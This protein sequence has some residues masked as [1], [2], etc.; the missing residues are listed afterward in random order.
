VLIDLHC[1][2]TASDGA[3]SPEALWALALAR[4]VRL[5]ALTDHDSMAGYH[6]LVDSGATGLRLLAGVELSCQ[7]AGHNIHIVGLG[8]DAQ[9]P[10]LLQGLRQQAEA[11][12]ARARGIGERLARAGIDGAYQGAR[13][14]A[15]EAMIGRPHFAQFLCESG[16]VRHAPEAFDRY[17]GAGKPGDIKVHWPEL[18]TAIEWIRAAGGYAV[19]AHPLHYRLTNARLGR[20]LGSF[21]EAGG[22]AM[23]VISGNQNTDQTRHMARLCRQHHLLASVGSDFHGP[24]TPWRNLGMR[25]WLPDD[26]QPI[27]EVLPQ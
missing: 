25:A 3:L 5:L 26:C 9:H 18:A 11:R 6:A 7:W 21:V 20:L 23:E 15:G 12:E 22:Q 14:I 17:L 27:W 24:T 19:L 2:S 13:R 8:L 4:G 10:Q 16:A 1:H